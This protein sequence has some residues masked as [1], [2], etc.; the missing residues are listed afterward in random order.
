MN[1]TYTDIENAVTNFK[2]RPKHHLIDYEQSKIKRIKKLITKHFVCIHKFLIINSYVAHDRD[3]PR[4]K[5]IHSQQISSPE[6]KLHF[7]F[8]SILLVPI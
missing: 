7:V 8:I 6:T 4:K 5:N 1:Q 2:H 3:F